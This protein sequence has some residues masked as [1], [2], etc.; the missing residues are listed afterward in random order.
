MVSA[1]GNIGTMVGGGQTMWELKA[2]ED[3]DCTMDDS[4]VYVII[5]RVVKKM[6]HKGIAGE[7]V[8]VRADL[9]TSDGEPIISFIGKANNVRKH[10]I[11]YL[12]NYDY[13]RPGTWISSE[14]A[15]YI[16]YELHRAESESN[17][18]QD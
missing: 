3:I 17:Y 15:S 4:G 16:G 11:K 6:V 10:L 9:M 14:H 18:V 5:S 13:H 7:V 1:I 12:V 2:V 8:Q